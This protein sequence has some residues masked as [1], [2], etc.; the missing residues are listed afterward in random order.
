[1]AAMDELEAAIE[2]LRGILAELGEGQEEEV[3]E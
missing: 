3:V 2:E 1:V